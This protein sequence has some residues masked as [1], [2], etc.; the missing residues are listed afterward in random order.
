VEVTSYI[1]T[2]DPTIALPAEDIAKLAKRH[3]IDR[4]L[5]EAIIGE[6]A[7]YYGTTRWISE[8]GYDK[9]DTLDEIEKPITALLNLLGH[10]V[11]RHRLFVRLVGVQDGHAVNDVVAVGAKFDALVPFLKEVR[12]AA[13]DA[14]WARGRGRPEAKADLASAYRFLARRYRELFGDKAFT[15]NWVKVPK[16]DLIKPDLIKK[17]LAPIAQAAQFVFDVIKIIDPDRPCLAEE[18]RDLMTKTVATLPG[19]RRGRA[20]NLC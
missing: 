20:A 1:F 16:P 17:D 14:H 3:K 2:S 7:W 18:L 11:N 13:R 12:L 9:P 5:L 4:T 6:A 10:E 8:E 15:Q 19:P